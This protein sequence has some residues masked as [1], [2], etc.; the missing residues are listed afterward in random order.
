MDLNDLSIFRMAAKRMSWLGKR[1]QV[2]AQNIANS[3][4]PGYKPNDLKA[5]D[6]SR[7]VRPQTPRVALTTTA[8]SHMDPLRKPPQFR[9]QSKRDTYEVAPSGNAVVIEEQ[10]MKINETQSNFRLTSN[11]YQ[12]HL[13][14]LKA[15]L[16]RDR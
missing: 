14:M 4:T 1:Q 15:A 11:L 5:L 16:G 9:P 10:L 7:F 2:L 8:S 3:D 12:K 6:F 13:T